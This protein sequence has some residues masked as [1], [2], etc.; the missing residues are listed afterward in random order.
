MSRV[1]AHNFDRLAKAMMQRHNV[2]YSKAIELL[3]TLRL[4]LICGDEIHASAALQAALLTAVNSG[5]RAFRG[6]VSVELPGEVKLHLLWPGSETLADA[7]RS[8]GATVGVKPPLDA[9][10]L[11]LGKTFARENGLR[12]LCDGWR[13]GV[14]PS[15]TQ[16]DFEAGVDFALAGV[17]A[18]GLAVGRA[19]LS[20]AGICN[21]DVTEPTGISLW[22]PGVHWLSPEAKGPALT[23]LPEK[24]WLLGLGHLGQ[25][26]AWTLG[27]LP[28]AEPS[29]TTIF[30]QD[31]DSV[32]PGN[33]SAGLL[34]EAG[35]V[36][37]MK[38][39]LCADWLQARG[40][41]TR[42]IER[43]FDEGFHRRPDEPRVALCGFDNA[44]SR[45]S[46]EEVG[47]ELIVESG[48]GATLDRF[49]RIV[50]H[51]FP[52][53]SAKARDIWEKD[54]ADESTFDL[55]L[56]EEAEEECGI[57]LQEIAGKSI[58]SSFTGACASALVVSEV[59]RA[60]HG[61]K[62]REFIALHLRDFEIPKSPNRE[63]N[64]QLR[65]AKNGVVAATPEDGSMEFV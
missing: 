57:V 33:W 12:V 29:R 35:G 65:V 61:G 26:Y 24:L 27:L 32:E 46:L 17:F 58:S 20:A 8:L 3:A 38:T 13:A 34:C 45:R 18:G 60:I 41:Q 52:D 21:R 49:D 10:I 23:M 2:K 48:L 51:T 42:M 50:L 64:Y 7:A 59:L 53:A 11:I 25:A 28:F 39:R 15:D 36:G 54:Q 22:E 55:S 56:L 62:R 4:H 31:F 19:F 9:S 40:L 44:E 1:T 37:K 47:F 5:K 30:L 43:A 63:E 14:L 16:I 6:G